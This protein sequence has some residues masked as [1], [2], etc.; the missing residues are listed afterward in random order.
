MTEISLSGK[1][2]VAALPEVCELHGHLDEGVRTAI[3]SLHQ[4]LAEAPEPEDLQVRVLVQ[5]EKVFFYF[6][7]PIP[8][9][10][11]SSPLDGFYFHVRLTNGVARIIS[12]P[13]GWDQE[14]NLH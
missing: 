7:S 6:Y 14:S 1:C 5:P 12:C 2:R 13:T 8:R 10:Y 3:A 4:R 9:S 11:S